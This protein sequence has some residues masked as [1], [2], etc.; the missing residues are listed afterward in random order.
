MKKKPVASV[1]ERGGANRT[2]YIGAVQSHAVLPAR[3]GSQPRELAVRNR[4]GRGVL[5]QRSNVGGIRVHGGPGA[6]NQNITRQVRHLHGP[7]GVMVLGDRAVDLN[8]VAADRR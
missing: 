7:G 1:T 2:L 3:D 8:L 4:K 5:G 6:P